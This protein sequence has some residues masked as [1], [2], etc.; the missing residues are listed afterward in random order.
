VL[1]TDAEEILVEAAKP[2]RANPGPQE[3]VLNQW[4]QSAN[5]V[6]IHF[7]S[8]LS[9]V[10]PEPDVVGHKGSNQSPRGI[11]ANEEVQDR[12]SGRLPKCGA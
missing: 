5:V 4:V 7:K 9:D 2:L 3:H 1:G 11:D 8:I 10:T 12:C 6:A